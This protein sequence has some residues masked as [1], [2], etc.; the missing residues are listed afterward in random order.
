MPVLA[1]LANGSQACIAAPPSE[2]LEKLH[3]AAETHR[4]AGDLEQTETAV[5][6]IIE[7]CNIVTGPDAIQPDDPKRIKL[8]LYTVQLD[9]PLGNFQ[10]A[11][12]TCQSIAADGKPGSI[13]VLEAM[14]GP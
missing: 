8:L 11:L 13:D 5:T 4:M 14:L 12:S 9:L 6:A 2:Q 7:A 10:R 1:V 3:Q